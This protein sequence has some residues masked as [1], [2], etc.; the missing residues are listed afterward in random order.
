MASRRLEIVQAA[1]A[2]V[3]GALDGAG[4]ATAEVRGFDASYAVPANGGLGGGAALGIVLDP[5]DP[6][7]DLSPLHY[8]YALPVRVELLPP[9]GAANAA[10]A[11]DTMATAIGAAVAADRTL[12]G[13]ADWAEV[14]LLAENEDAAPNAPALRWGALTLMIDFSTAHPLGR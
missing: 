1:R 5:D 8:H 14:T 6:E 3:R 11:L 10:A 9:D 7:I 13:I 12:G 2:L 4:Y